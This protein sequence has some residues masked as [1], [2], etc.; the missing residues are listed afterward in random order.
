MEANWHALRRLFLVGK[1][2][3]SNLIGCNA[4]P[5]RIVF[6]E[7]N[8]PSR[9]PTRIRRGEQSGPAREQSGP[10]GEESG[11]VGEQSGPASCGQSNYTRRSSLSSW[12]QL[13]DSSSA[14]STPVMEH[15]PTHVMEDYSGSRIPTIPGRGRP[16]RGHGGAL[17][18]TVDRPSG[19]DGQTED[20]P[21]SSPQNKRNPAWSPP[22]TPD[23][24]A[25][26]CCAIVVSLPGSDLDGQTVTVTALNR[27]Y[28]WVVELVD[29]HAACDER[30]LD[31]RVTKVRR[32][33]LQVAAARPAAS[34]TPEEDGYES[35]RA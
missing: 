25:K 31:G 2:S 24:L 22:P 5:V 7:P 26:G 9:T 17:C 10:A 29:Q 23:G 33:C 34:A 27:Q 3:L 4:M 1:L 30:L 13:L 19:D 28:A 21:K 11:P 6:H 35:G 32:E 12:L 8:S 16:I 20:A 14:P 18:A 15:V